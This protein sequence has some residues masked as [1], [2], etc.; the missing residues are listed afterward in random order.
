MHQLVLASG[1]PR[2]K[3]ILEEAGYQF[4][5]LPTEI[6]EILN[7][8]LRLEDQIS[9][10]AR[11]KAVAAGESLKL[12]ESKPYLVLGADTVVVH[13]TQVI[14]KPKSKEEAILILNQLSGEIHRVITGFCLFDLTKDHLILGHQTTEIIFKNLTDREIHEYVE[15]GDPM[16]KAGAYG[17]QGAARA[18]VDSIKGSYENVVGLPLTE[19][20]KVIQENGWQLQRS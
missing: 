9:D 16:D 8:N 4:R 17:I 2:R 11:Q 12:L 15:T 7:K 3:K 14:G 5:T 13:S 19:I 6:S 20:E 18:F 1:S 10:C